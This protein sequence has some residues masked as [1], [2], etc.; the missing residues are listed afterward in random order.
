MLFQ[1]LNGIRDAQVAL[2]ETKLYNSTV[3]GIWGPGCQKA[4]SSLFGYHAAKKR[5]SGLTPIPAFIDDPAVILGLQTNLKKLGYYTG[6]LDGIWGDGCRSGISKAAVDYQEGNNLPQYSACWSKK[7]SPDF[8]ISIRNW[9]AERRMSAAC[10]D[11]LMAII[12]FESGGT[13]DPAKQ[14][15]AGAHYFGLIQFGDAAAA[16][17]GTTVDELVKMSQLQQL[18]YVF[19]YFD[20]R[21][22]QK[23]LRHLEDFYMSVFY[24]AAI[25]S[26]A[27]TV[28]FS[29]GVKGYTQ[30]NGLDVDHDGKITVGEINIKIYQ[31]YY[32]GML[33]ANRS[34]L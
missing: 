30:N 20:M 5:V 11:Y 6:N 34:T 31:S 3:D 18:Q 26:S 24:P 27:D 4:A 9:V 28:I 2:V 1:V 8:I 23:P 17:L 21:M 33:P 13:F 15:N 19:K 12:A 22:R 25:G 7:V 14:N 32:N 16:D 29:N 10:V